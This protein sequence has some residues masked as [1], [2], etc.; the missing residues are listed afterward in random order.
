[1]AARVDPAT[2]AILG[3]DRFNGIVLPGTGFPDEARGRIDVA[4][5]PEYQRLFRGLPEG[6][7]ETHSAVFQPRLGLAYRINDK[8][9][10]R[11]GAGV[12]HTRVTLNDSTCSAATRRSSSWSA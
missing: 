9:V 11:L 8:T 1:V 5:N 12:Y 3:G 6:F 7:S 4:D 10:W 2:G